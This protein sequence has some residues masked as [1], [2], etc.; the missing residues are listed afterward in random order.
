MMTLNI[1]DEFPTILRGVYNGR[2]NGVYSNKEASDERL[3]G[4]TSSP[5]ACN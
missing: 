5:A 2:F 4:A 3:N 1:F